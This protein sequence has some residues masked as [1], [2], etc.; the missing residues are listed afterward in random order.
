MYTGQ[1]WDVD[2]SSVQ[3]CLYILSEVQYGNIVVLCSL[4]Y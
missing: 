3:F 2:S 4:V 1:M